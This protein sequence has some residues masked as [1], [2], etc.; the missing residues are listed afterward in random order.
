MT[1]NRLRKMITSQPFRPFHICMSN[2]QVY[3]VKHP[4]FLA[5]S[6]RDDIA[7]LIHEDGDYSVLDLLLMSEIKVETKKNRTK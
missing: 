1:S 6:P 7:I 2:G 5:V 3:E 4:E